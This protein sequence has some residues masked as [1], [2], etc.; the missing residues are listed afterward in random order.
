MSLLVTAASFVLQKVFVDYSSFIGIHKGN[1]TF[2]NPCTAIFQM[3]FT[4][5]KI[6]YACYWVSQHN[7]ENNVFND[8]ISFTGPIKKIN[9][10]DYPAPMPQ[11]NL[12]LIF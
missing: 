9:V 6:L 3:C 1:Q 12:D 7:V 4:N 2:C 10:K 11:R 5:C 8:D